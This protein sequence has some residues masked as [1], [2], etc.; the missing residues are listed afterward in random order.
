MTFL[1]AHVFEAPSLDSLVK[2]YD[3]L[4]LSALFGLSR[5]EEF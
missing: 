3:L 1:F 4:S 2:D 5:S